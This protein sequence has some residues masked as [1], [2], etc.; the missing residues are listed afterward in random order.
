MKLSQTTVLLLYTFC[1]QY[2]KNY[3][4]LI[5]WCCFLQDD[6]ALKYI[7]YFHFWLLVVYKVIYY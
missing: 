5:F 2:Y 6:Q 7:Q 3:P 4:Q 1:L